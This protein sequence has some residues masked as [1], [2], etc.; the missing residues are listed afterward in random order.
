MEDESE[1]AA[2][3]PPPTS[4][5]F[6]GEMKVKSLLLCSSCFHQLVDWI[7]SIIFFLLKINRKH[8]LEYT[9]IPVSL[10]CYSITRLS[11]LLHPKGHGFSWCL[12]QSAALLTHFRLTYRVNILLFKTNLLV[13]LLE[14]F[15]R[16]ICF[17]SSARFELTRTHLKWVL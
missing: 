9:K 7:Y 5:D 4:A 13:N 6:E 1:T 10:Q 8:H 14:A 12:S 15:V 17:R 11:R 2:P 3:P 16:C